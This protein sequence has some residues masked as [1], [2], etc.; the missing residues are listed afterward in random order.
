MG[1][2]YITQ[3]IVL[4]NPWE[5][6]LAVIITKGTTSLTNALIAMVVSVILYQLI[7]PALK[8]ANLFQEN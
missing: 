1:K 2:T 5:T 8:R 6:T 3:A 4:G 7:A